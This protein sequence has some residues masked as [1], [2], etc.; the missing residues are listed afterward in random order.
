MNDKHEFKRKPRKCPKCNSKRIASI[1]YGMPAYSEKLESDMQEG[2]IVL[3]G[4][5]IEDGAPNW[6]CADCDTALF[7]YDEDENDLYGLS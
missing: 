4:C 7:K 3:G 2:N 1:L 6:V 5:C